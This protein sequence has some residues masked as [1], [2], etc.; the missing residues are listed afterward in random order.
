[1]ITKKLTKKEI[2]N[3]KKLFNENAAKLKPNRKSGEEVDKYFNEKYECVTIN[4]KEF[5]NAVKGNLLYLYN[6]LYFDKLKGKTPEIKCYNANGAFVGIDVVS[7][8][9]HVECADINKAAAIYDDLFVFRGL[10]EY[11]LK[12][13]VLVGQYLTLKR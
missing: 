4:D 11:D 13:Y 6:E 5:I 3:F 7:G 10:D 1:M 8:E 9:F 2:E 12:N